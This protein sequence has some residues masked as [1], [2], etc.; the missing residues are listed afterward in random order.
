MQMNIRG[1]VGIERTGGVL[2]EKA[3]EE[4]DYEHSHDIM[5]H[6]N[7]GSGRSPNS[8]T[9]NGK[10]MKMEQEQIRKRQAEVHALEM[11][12]HLKRAEREKKKQ[13]LESEFTM[14]FSE[15]ERKK[16]SLE[17]LEV[18]IADMEATRQRKDREFSRLQRNLM[19]LLQEQKYELDSLRE[20]GI[21][22]ETA[23]AT[24]AAAAAAT[25][26]KAKEH[27]KQTSVMFNQQEELMKFQFMSMSLSYFSSLNMLKQMREINSDTTASAISS[28]ADT[29]AAAAAASAAANIPSIKQLK[30]GAT[31]SVDAAIASKEAELRHISGREADAKQ[32]KE[33]PF[34][35]EV[36]LWTVKEVSRWLQTLSL[37]SLREKGIELETATAT[38]AAAAAATAQKAKEHEKQTSVMFN[39]QEEL[40]KFQ[41]MSMSLSY[42]SSLNMLKQMRE[43]NSDTTAS[44][45]SSSAD[46]AAAAAAASAAANIPSIKQLKLG[47]TDSVDAAIASKEAELRHISGREA[48]AKQAK[49]EPFPKEVR[50]WTVKEVSRWLQTLSLGIY[51]TAFEEACVDGEFLQELREEDLSGVLGVEHKLHRRK[52][53]LAREKLKPLGRMEVAK[54]EEVMKE[55]KAVKRRVEEDVPDTMTV[56]SQVRHGRLKRVEES[57][58]LGFN[59]NTEEE[60]GN[61]I[62]MCAVQNNHRKMLD[63]ILNRGGTINHRNTSGNTALHYALAYDTSGEIAEFLIEKGADDTIENNDGLTCYD[64]LG[65]GA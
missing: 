60:K 4:D 40:M 24:S 6:G 41:F 48:D 7:S 65:S 43:I 47:A 31:D 63:L 33:E 17:R 30:L 16:A 45:I 34:P 20:K 62:L 27:E 54:K 44:A 26:Q 58:R 50:L 23:T 52:I 2:S 25:A 8:K 64:G 59:I 39:Q 29:A 51:C 46:T 11:A 14:V 12:I 1:A 35:K 10:S 22:L 18:A 57:I 37:G 21:E 38:S 5:D 55:D 49:E 15:V 13:E 19:E 9:K 56:F 61:T 53:L 36:R 32:A 42:F 28:S 3:K